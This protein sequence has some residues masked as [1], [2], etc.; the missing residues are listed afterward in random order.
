M[1]SYQQRG[2]IHII[3]EAVPSLTDALIRQDAHAFKHLHGLSTYIAPRM[4]REMAQDTKKGDAS[5]QQ[6][7]DYIQYLKWKSFEKATSDYAPSNSSQ[8]VDVRKDTK[9]ALLKVWHKDFKAHSSKEFLMLAFRNKDVD[10]LNAGARFLLKQSG[11]IAK[12]EISYKTSRE[13]QDDFGKR[14]STLTSKA[15]SKGDRIVFTRNNYGL[16]V[17]NGTLG[18][19]VDLNK[20][21]ITVTLS[22]E[23]RT[24]SF[25]PSLNPFF[26]HGW[27]MTIHKTQGTTTDKTYVLASYDMTQNLTYVAMTRHREDVQVFGSS[28]D[29]WRPEKLPEILAISGEKLAARDYLGPESLEQLMKQED[30]LLS[31]IFTRLRSEERRVGK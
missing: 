14:T 19:I 20:S 13:T 17:K 9:E 11:H 3:E 4:Y 26:D 2:H 16:N 27:A 24:V 25:A 5:I 15:F 18:T 30:K 22:E 6:H 12:E 7:P 8:E 31:K 29:F 10:D 1:Q 21:L 28:I 23:D